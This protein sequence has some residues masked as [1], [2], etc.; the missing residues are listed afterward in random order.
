LT[1]VTGSPRRSLLG[2]VVAMLHARSR[3]RTG[4]PSR[5]AA[6]IKDHLLTFCAMGLID[7][8]AFHWSPIAG[9][10]ITGLSLL[11]ADFKI[12]D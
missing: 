4:Q 3:A 10:I 11:V 8:G 2:T 5:L 7:T 6:A 9:F 1:A 12:Q